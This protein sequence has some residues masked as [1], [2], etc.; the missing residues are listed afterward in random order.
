M[1]QPEPHTSFNI[2]MPEDQAVGHYADFAAI[3][4][5]PE[6]FVLDFMALAQPPQP[7]PENPP[8]QVAHAQL[9]SRVRI[10]AAQVWEIMKAL[11]QQYSAWEIENGHRPPGD[12]GLP[13]A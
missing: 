9:A 1:S 2:N 13:T 11:E 12:P 4:H 6:T 3:W 7:D 5:T 8:H 10:P